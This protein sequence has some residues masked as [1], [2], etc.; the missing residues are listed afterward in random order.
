MG[1]PN[2]VIRSLET[3]GLLIIL[4]FGIVKY[5]IDIRRT[6]RERERVRDK[7]E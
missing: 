7:D 2:V 5:I 1:E 4:I 3:A 6:M